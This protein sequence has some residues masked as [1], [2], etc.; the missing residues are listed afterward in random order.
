MKQWQWILDGGLSADG[1]RFHLFVVQLS[2]T[3]TSYL[4][5]TRPTGLRRVVLDTSTLEVVAVHDEQPQGAGLSG[6][7]V[8]SDADYTYLYSHCYQQFGY[9]TVLGFG[10]CVREV[11]LARVP[12]GE[13]DADREYWHGAGWTTDGTRSAP[14][15][16]ASFVGSGNNPAHIRFDGE[17]FVL[18]EKRDDWWGTTVEFGVANDPHGPSRHVATVEEPLNCDRSECNTYFASWIPWDDSDGTH[19]WSIGH[20]RWNGSETHNH[21]ADYRPTFLTISL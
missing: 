3:G 14:V 4:S 1:A 19:I 15:V 12:L 21:L 16:D 6:W 8:T 7:S 18:V 11:G 9:D 10:A 2:E 5:R 13:F 17:K 20:N